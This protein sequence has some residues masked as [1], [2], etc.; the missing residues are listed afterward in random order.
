MP[1]PVPVW[2]CCQCQFGPWNSVTDTHCPNCQ[3]LRCKNCTVEMTYARNAFV[4]GGDDEGTSPY[5]GVPATIFD[6][7]SNTMEDHHGAATNGVLSLASTSQLPSLLRR[8]DMTRGSRHHQ[9][10]I[11]THGPKKIRWYCCSCGDGPMLYANH[12]QCVS[13]EHAICPNCSGA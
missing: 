1:K 4:C 11:V 5:P 2:F 12:V 7:S 13:C 3:T 6:P 8:S 9:Q 10:G